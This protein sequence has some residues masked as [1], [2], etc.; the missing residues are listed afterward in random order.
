MV[1][2]RL[3]ILPKPLPP[4]KDSIAAFA[5]G[6]M[7]VSYSD[8]QCLGTAS[9]LSED[10]IAEDGEGACVFP[11]I[12]IDQRGARAVWVCEGRYVCPE[13]ASGCAAGEGGACVAHA[14]IPLR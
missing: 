6:W 10:G 1:G 12:E 2:R 3:L 14:P 9:P 11:K 5:S 13:A 4:M 8:Y 7:A